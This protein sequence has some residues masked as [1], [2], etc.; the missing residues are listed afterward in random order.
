MAANLNELTANRQNCLRLVCAL[1]R[2]VLVPSRAGWTQVGTA[3]DSLLYFLTLLI[4]QLENV[5][6][7]QFRL[8]DYI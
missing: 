5:P 2:G 3:E 1:D 4:Q 8:G 6:D 7:R